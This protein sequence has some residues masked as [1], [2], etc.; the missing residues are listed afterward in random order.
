[1]K[2]IR[3]ALGSVL[4]LILCA[5]PALANADS[6]LAA[7][8]AGYRKPLLELFNDFEKRTGIKAEA[9][10]GHLKQIET[11]ARQNPD[12]ALMVADKDFLIPLGL[13]DSYARL[14]AGKLALI[15]P[16]G[17]NISSLEDLHKTEVQRIATPD[18]KR[19][20]YGK[21]A[22]QCLD[23]FGWTDALKSKIIENDTVP[24]V[25][26][27]VALSEVD[28]GFVNLTEA[29]AQGDKIGGYIEA[30]S[31]CYRP[32]EISVAVMKGREDEPAVKAW[33]DYIS[34][35]SARQILAGYG[36]D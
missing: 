24:Q 6:L 4:V 1:M 28:A 9:S 36:L 35:D 17:K 22:M 3:A 13:A 31:E 32:I 14:G 12:I 21:A 25:G 16:K 26:S 11:Q 27:Y 34:T 29:L 15:Y 23:H 8:G 2:R 20:M 33:L 19:A 7:A 10:F 30:P 18:H 5:G